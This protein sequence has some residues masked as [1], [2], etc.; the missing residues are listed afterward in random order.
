MSMWQVKVKEFKTQ[1]SRFGTI[2]PVWIHIWWWNDAQSLMLLRR[3]A[4]LFCKVIR[5][6]SRSHGTKKLPILT[7]IEHSRSVTPD[8]IKRWIW[9]VAQSLK[10]HR[11]GVRLFFKV[12]CHIARSHWTKKSTILTRIEH[13]RTVTPVLIKQWFKM[14]HK[15]WC[16]VEE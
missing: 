6:I 7:W 10:K 3:G 9:N 2:S 1:L 5:E 12:I 11:K 8:L 14:M 4:L 13:F 16:R 15:A